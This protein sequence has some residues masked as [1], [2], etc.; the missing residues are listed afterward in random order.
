MFSFV[1]TG[2]R[3]GRRG[4]GRGHTG[5]ARGGGLRSPRVGTCP[6]PGNSS[7]ADGASAQR[8]PPTTVWPQGAGAT[9]G[10][11]LEA[12][13][14][15]SLLPRTTTQRGR[16]HGAARPH[17]SGRTWGTHP[18]PRRTACYST[19]VCC[20][21]MELV[22]GELPHS[23]GERR[24]NEAPATAAGASAR[25]TGTGTGSGWADGRLS[26][27]GRCVSSSVRFG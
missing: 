27:A 11:S 5:A 7:T 1:V 2:T 6:P 13:S 10:T 15:A 9:R 18:A 25:G 8:T 12:L 23:L 4:G 14:Q 3:G 21:L 24:V 16:R 19:Q 26:G 22:P 20:Q 17:R